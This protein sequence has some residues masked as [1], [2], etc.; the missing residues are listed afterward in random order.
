MDIYTRQQCILLQTN[1]HLGDRLVGGTR[2][3][4]AHWYTYAWLS[5]IVESYTPYSAT[6]ETSSG[7]N[8]L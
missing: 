3:D 8:F 2:Q 7:R 1:C 4:G 5:C 6:C